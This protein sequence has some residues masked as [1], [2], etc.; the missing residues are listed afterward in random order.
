MSSRLLST[1]QLLSLAL[2]CCG[3]FTVTGRLPDPGSLKA[4]LVTAGL[5]G[6]A[7][8]ALFRS[9]PWGAAPFLLFWLYGYFR[10][11]QTIGC[12]TAAVA[13]AGIFFA[14]FVGYLRIPLKLRWIVPPLALICVARGV[15][16]LITLSPLGLQDS[17]PLG[18]MASFFVS[19]HVF[20]AF[21]ILCIFFHFYLMEKGE[22]HKPVQALL[23]FSTSVV[24]L[25]LLLTDSRLSQGA[26]L[27]CFL[28][29]LFLSLRLDGK[30]P[31]LERIAW[32]TGITL[33][34]GLAWVHLPESQLVKVASYLS[35][36][37]SHGSS[38]GWTAAYRVFRAAPWFGKGLGGFRFA[39]EEVAGARPF[40]ADDVRPPPLTHAGNHVLE[41][42]AELG[43]MGMALE[44]LILACA[45][46]AMAWFYYREWRVEAKYG[47]FCIVA[48]FLMGFFSPVL[49][50]AP[51]R[52]I[53]WALLGFGYSMFVEAFGA[54]LARYRDMLP[55][56]SARIAAA[57]LS[58]CLLALTAGHLAR[59]T[60]EL[61]SDA[62]FMRLPS[63]ITPALM[64]QSNDL[65]VETLR[66][67][68]GNEEANYAYVKFLGRYNM[69]VSALQRLYFVKSFAPDPTRRNE[70][71]SML[72]LEMGRSDS[73]AAY[74]QRVVEKHPNHLASLETLA[75]AL[76][77]M[78]A[79]DA[80]DE[81]REKNAELANVY[82]L[83]A[84][85]AYTVEALDNLFNSN[86]DLNFVQR[87]FGGEALRKR[88]V[89]RQLAA[90][91]RSQENHERA[92]A[93][94]HARCPEA[95]DSLKAAP[96]KAPEH[97]LYRKWRGIGSLATRPP[98]MG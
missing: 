69:E 66:I 9:V 1:L 90:Y 36:T 3:L 88:F 47:F 59:R 13:H 41:S 7:L 62:V 50:L 22:P 92:L 82:P 52:F 55:R 91:A 98:P 18:T 30:E 67:N 34:L 85:Q 48:L 93:L 86:E 89:E 24:L 56:R 44:I 57:L 65:L 17:E 78:R 53:Y 74:A 35:P 87:W 23:Y 58:I 26:F 10:L 27:V 38:W 40:A 68:P 96:K 42:L 33:C 81:L 51:A 12:Q 6:L 60:I 75:G 21:L 72:Y 49:E 46:F 80:L 4:P 29:L 2:I 31:A 61:R 15:M 79:C 11:T 43:A 16:D 32:I 97:R 37:G 95:E 5:M 77:A 14:F 71:L 73:A 94:M 84:P 83:P 76:S 64:K 45:L 8:P 63:T 54:R 19:K 28:P 25:A 70:A 39:A 20:G